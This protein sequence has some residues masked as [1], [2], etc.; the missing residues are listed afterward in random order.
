MHAAAGDADASALADVIVATRWPTFGRPLTAALSGFAAGKPVIV[1]ETESTARWA[2]LDPQTWQPR[3]IAA[4]PGAA[5]PPIAISIDPRDE[6][7]SLMLALVRLAGDAALRAALGGAA[8]AWWEGHATVPH[9]VAAWRELL[10]EAKTLP[11]PPRPAG[12]PRTSTPP[13][14]PR[15]ARS[16]ISSG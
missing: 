8:R 11:P 12:G 3:S 10:A 1:A 7:H 13:A 14:T 6:E 4:G 15:C 9:A 5:G 16:W 2:A